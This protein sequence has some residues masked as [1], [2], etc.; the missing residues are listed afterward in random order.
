MGSR[1]IGQVRFRVISRDHAGAV[2]NVHA[3]VGSGEVIVELTPAG[4]RLSEAHSG[5]IRGK[6]AKNELRIVLRTARDSYQQ[7]IELWE[8]SQP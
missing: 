2:P 5:V 1:R 3:D 7:L 4:V 6:I 8:G